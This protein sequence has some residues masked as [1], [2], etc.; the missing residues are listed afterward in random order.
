MAQE[1]EPRPRDGGGALGGLDGDGE[2]GVVEV[3]VVPRWKVVVV[4]TVWEKTV[5][6][7]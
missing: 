2:A 6:E 3:M 4:E 5:A 1:G 7:V